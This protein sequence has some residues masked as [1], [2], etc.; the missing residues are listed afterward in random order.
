[1]SRKKNPTFLDQVEQATRTKRL[2]DKE[3]NLV[4]KLGRLPEFTADEPRVLRAL[5]G[6]ARLARNRQFYS[7]LRR[8]ARDI[9]QTPEWA[10]IGPVWIRDNIYDIGAEARDVSKGP[11]PPVDTVTEGASK[12]AGNSNPHGGG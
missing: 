1:M 6:Q 2:V 11:V 5:R 12:E 4:Q 9:E 8:V 10:H 7:W 3:D